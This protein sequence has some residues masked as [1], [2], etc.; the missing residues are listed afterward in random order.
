MASSCVDEQCTH[1][2]LP[3]AKL[4]K[5]SLYYSLSEAAIIC[6]ECDFV[7]SPKLASEHP[8]K[9]HGIAR[10]ARHGLRPLLSS[11]IEPSRSR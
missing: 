8:G 6:I 1:P 11:I 7:L 10:S 5:L 3:P 4:Q 9:K 2:I